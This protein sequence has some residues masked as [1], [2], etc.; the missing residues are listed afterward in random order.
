MISFEQL[1]L[2][3]AQKCLPKLGAVPP[4]DV[5]DERGL[6]GGFKFVEISLNII[7]SNFCLL[8]QAQKWLP[9]LGAV[10]PGDVLDEGGLQGGVKFVEISSNIIQSNFCFVKQG[11]KCHFQ[12][13]EGPGG[14]GG[15]PH[16]PQLQSGLA[17]VGVRQSQRDQR[18][19]VRNSKLFKKSF[20]P[21]VTRNF[22][23]ILEGLL[24]AQHS[25]VP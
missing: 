20:D 5:L 12:P 4:G 6:Q 9:K 22:F 21:R 18:H 3:Q 24:S 25:I 10:P 17:L 11:Q 8:K 23:E 7:Q 15:Q 2:K 16:G 13:L 14:A 1:L 19:C